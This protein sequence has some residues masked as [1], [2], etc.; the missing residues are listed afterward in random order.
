[1]TFSTKCKMAW[2]STVSYLE[3]FFNKEKEVMVAHE[4]VNG[5]GKKQGLGG[6]SKRAISSERN[7]VGG[8]GQE[9]GYPQDAPPPGGY[10]EGYQPGPQF[11]V[12]YN[13]GSQFQGEPFQIPAEVPDPMNCYGGVPPPGDMQGCYPPQVPPGY[14]GQYM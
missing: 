11:G 5:G 8:Y 13:Q 3:G 14:P 6:R 9:E 12:E 2:G 4:T 10:Y 7:N 1:M